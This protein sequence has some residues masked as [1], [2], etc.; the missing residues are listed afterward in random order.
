ML[1][2][3][4]V[5]GADAARTA[6]SSRRWRCI[7]RPT[8]CSTIST[9]CI[10]ARA[11]WAAPAL[12]FAEMTCVSPDARITPG[13]LGLWNDE[14]AAR[15]EA[16]RRFHPRDAGAK[17]GI[18]LGHAGRKGSTK[19][20]LGGHRSAARDGR[21]A[22]DL[23][24]G[25]CLP[26]ERPDPARH[27]ARRHG[28]GARRFR[29]RH[30]TRGRRPASTGSSCTARTAI[31]CR[32]SFRRS[33]TGATTNTAAIASRTGRAI[34]SKCSARCAR[35]GRRTGRCRCVSRVTTGREGG[36]T[37]DDAAIFAEMFKDAGADLIDC[38]SG[39]V[40]KAEQP[41]YGRMFQT[42]FSD[43]IRNEA[44]SSTRSR[45]AR[46]RRPT[47]P[48]RSSPPAAPISARSP[49]RISPTPPGRCTRPPRSA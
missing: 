38:S 6:S 27:D 2:P 41:V 46:S 28:P 34:R 44:A 36:N 35:P 45:S 33:P 19:R 32:A 13:C 5:R 49:G 42:P 16:P 15:V 43:K 4:R 39:Q 22:A 14:Q 25:R 9:S 37:P 7:R 47:T 20:R 10:S 31:C 21:L 48:I 24:V 1:T 8:A 40:S 30:P 29:R 12:V 23:G 18:Q 11:R 17:V 3:Y 26:A